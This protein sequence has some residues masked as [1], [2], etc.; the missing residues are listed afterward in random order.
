MFIYDLFKCCCLYMGY[1]NC[2]SSPEKGKVLNML[3][4]KKSLFY[5][6]R[7]KKNVCVY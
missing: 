2:I 4:K 6:E 1:K 7:F 5:L 3:F